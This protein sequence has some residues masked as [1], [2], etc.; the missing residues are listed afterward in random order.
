MAQQVHGELHVV[1]AYRHTVVPAY[2]RAEMDCPAAMVGSVFP[3]L[4]EPRL[5]LS[6]RVLGHQWQEDEVLCRTI[7]CASLRSQH[8]LVARIE[9]GEGRVV[10][11]SCVVTAAA[12]QEREGQERS[13]GE[14]LCIVVADR[15]AVI[16]VLLVTG[17]L[18][19]SGS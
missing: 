8:T 5:Q 10:G 1:R 12:A 9:H 17:S 6:L 11:M 14:D 3:A 4:G 2:I 16:Q 7:I 13:A 15:N 19:A 18:Y